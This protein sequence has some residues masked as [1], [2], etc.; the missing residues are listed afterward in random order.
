M[1]N[2][3]RGRVLR[4]IS[5]AILGNAKTE[6]ELNSIILSLVNDWQ[7]G[8]DLSKLLQRIVASTNES[9]PLKHYEINQQPDALLQVVYDAIQRRR[10]SKQRLIKL[11]F[12]N[13]ISN[14]LPVDFEKKSVRDLIRQFLRQSNPKETARFLSSIGIGVSEDPYLRGIVDPNR[15]KK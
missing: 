2:D 9:A 12:E 7:L 5:A 14:H 13:S 11:F 8:P 10:I 4:I 15:L 3:I 6:K 1:K